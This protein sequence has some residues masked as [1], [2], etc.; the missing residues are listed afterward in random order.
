MKHQK[1]QKAFNCSFPLFLASTNTK[2]FDVQ[3]ECRI[4]NL[5]NNGSTNF[6]HIIKD[7]AQGMYYLLSD[8]RYLFMLLYN[9]IHEEF[10]TLK[11]V[12]S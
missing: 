2:E 11:L 5:G 6:Q 10:K 9:V 7:I 8:L 4:K 12:H 1:I 3:E